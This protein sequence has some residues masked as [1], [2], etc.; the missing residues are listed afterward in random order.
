[1]GKYTCD[2]KS[3]MTFRIFSGLA[4]FLAKHYIYSIRSDLLQTRNTYIDDIFI[5]KN[6][7]EFITKN[8]YLFRLQI[9]S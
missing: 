1:M 6:K 3:D 2:N 5:V 4:A 8:T 7:I 9:M